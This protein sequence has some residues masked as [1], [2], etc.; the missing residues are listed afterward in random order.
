M[1]QG[2]N[3]NQFQNMMMGGMGGNSQQFGMMSGN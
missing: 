2:Q 1:N 3:Q